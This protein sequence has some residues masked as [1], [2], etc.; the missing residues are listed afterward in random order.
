VNGMLK[1]KKNAYIMTFVQPR[2]DSLLTISRLS[3]S[4]QS[5]QSHEQPTTKM[6]PQAPWA[7]LL[8]THISHLKPCTFAL[9]TLSTH[10]SPTSLLYPAPP[11]SPLHQSPLSPRCR[12]L[13]HRGSFCCLP[14][15]AHN[16]LLHHN[17]RVY[18]SD[19]PTFTTDCRMAKVMGEE[20]TGGAEVEACFWVEATQN[21]WR[22][23]G[24]CWLLSE[25]SPVPPD[26]V[27]ARL[28]KR[29]NRGGDGEFSWKK[30]VQAHFGNLAPAMRGSFANPPPGAPLGNDVGKL[31]KGGKV[32]DRY[33]LADQGTAK[34][35][36]GNFR[37][38]VVVPNVV[39]RVDL[40]ADEGQARRWVWWWVGEDAK[41]D[42]VQRGWRECETYP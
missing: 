23:R 25:E 26:E 13:I 2:T 3:P 1:P 28:R 5:S 18:D 19:L 17:P 39:E 12:T 6:S 14:E 41:A 33:V 7:P 32:E 21:Q 38:G 15:N 10:P 8:Q 34:V 37:V 30:E 16:P 4:P 27:M 24:R 29:G 9:A 42:G 40:T 36:R 11:P 35:A 20:A 22:I 31:V